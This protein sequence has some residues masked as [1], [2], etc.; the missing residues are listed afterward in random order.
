MS[1]LQRQWSSSQSLYYAHVSAQ[2]LQANDLVF[3]FCSDY[4]YFAWLV[5]LPRKNQEQVHFLVF[6]ILLGR[7]QSFVSRILLY[8]KK[9]IS[10][11]SLTSALF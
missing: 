6:L 1:S 8:F 7:H 5:D 11:L 10:A 3:I 4:Y 9:E 2:F